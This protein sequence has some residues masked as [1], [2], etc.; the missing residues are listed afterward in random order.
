MWG[1]ICHCRHSSTSFG[2][3][4]SL[5][6]TWSTGQAKHL[7]R[8]SGQAAKAFSEIWNENAICYQLSW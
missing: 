8:G 6:V 4:D 7:K 3:C 1:A 5:E 2:R